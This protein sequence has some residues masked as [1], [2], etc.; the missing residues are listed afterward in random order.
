VVVPASLRDF[1]AEYRLTPRELEVAWC[2]ANGSTNQEIA[3]HL[4]LNVRTV[5]GH[6]QRCYEKLGV[7]SRTRLAVMLHEAARAD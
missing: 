2:A 1:A 7:H 6:L 4:Y 3:A 5:E